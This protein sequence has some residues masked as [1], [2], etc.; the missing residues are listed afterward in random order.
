MNPKVR[1]TLADDFNQDQ[2]CSICGQK[3]LHVV[4]LD[5]YPDYVNCDNCGSAF[6]V[7]D[8]GERV[9]YGKIPGTVCRDPAFCA[10]TMGLAGGDRPQGRF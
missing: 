7:E 6:V 2:A 4:H 3:R 9:M 8:G 10:P 1:T 5:A